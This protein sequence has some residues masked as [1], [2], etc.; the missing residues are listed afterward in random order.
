VLSV[1]G[2]LDLATVR[3]FLAPAHEPLAERRSLVIDLTQ[4]TFIDATALSQIIELTEIPMARVA[5][6]VPHRTQVAR[7]VSL[8]GPPELVI[9]ASRDAALTWID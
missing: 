8:V 5:T 1:L 9:F 6:I 4:C 3:D 2:E 7:V